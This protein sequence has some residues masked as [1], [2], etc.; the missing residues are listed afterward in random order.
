MSGI[1]GLKRS[2]CLLF[3]VGAVNNFSPEFVCFLSQLV[4]RIL[5]ILLLG[6]LSDFH[7]SVLTG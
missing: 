5:N 6:V 4:Q 7:F 3:Q 1:C 2:V